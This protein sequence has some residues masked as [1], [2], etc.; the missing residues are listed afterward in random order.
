MHKHL[1]KS[2]N[3]IFI[4]LVNAKYT[5]YTKIQ[6]LFYYELYGHFELPR[7]VLSTKA[8]CFLYT[9][10]F[11]LYGRLIINYYD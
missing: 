5:V 3:K 7:V 9:L 10:F 6:L 2:P 1:G 8:P 11:A 4:N